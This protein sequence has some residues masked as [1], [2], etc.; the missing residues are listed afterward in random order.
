MHEQQPKHDIY[1]L[2]LDSTLTQKSLYTPAVRSLTP[3]EMQ[4]RSKE[5]VQCVKVK[6]TSRG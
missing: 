5:Q 4:T 6:Q 3:L 1:F 2:L